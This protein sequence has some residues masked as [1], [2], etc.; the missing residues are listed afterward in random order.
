MIVRRFLLWARTASASD[1]AAGVRALA[2]AF[3]HAPMLEEDRREA[4]V[5]MLAMLDDPS[6]LV[7]RAMAEVLAGEKAPRAI[8]LGLARDQAD[9]A[10]FVLAAS[11]VLTQADL[12][13]AVA[14]GDDLTQCAVAQRSDV[15][16]ALAAAIVEVGSDNA[17]V[18]L[19]ENDHAEMA[20]STLQRA[21]DRAAHAP[22]LR[23]ALLKQPH[24]PIGIRHQLALNVAD[25][26]S[27][28]AGASGLM[29]RERA[30][31]VSRDASEK[32]AL[33]LAA[34]V[35]DHEE[36]L[37]VL[38]KQLRNSKRL[39]PGLILRSLLSGDTVLAEAALADLAG[40]PM[41]R[42]SSILRDRRGTGVAALCRKA[43]IP[44]MLVPAFV[45]AVEAV[46]VVGATAKDTQRVSMSRRIIE[47]VLIA[48]DGADDGTNAPLM[49]ML[50][51]FEA[52]AARAEA[53][54]MADTLA[55]EA[56]LAELLKIDPELT[57]LVDL[58]VAQLQ[59][60]N[61]TGLRAVA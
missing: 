33:E 48:C 56:A 16:I 29:T 15:S 12:I 40:M 17:I 57:L 55:D 49:A 50:R 3:L 54:M 45:A 11:P 43:D 22:T 61:E 35:D 10:A 58:E 23:E 20:A 51:R 19:I 26:L 9:V 60:A 2:E 36:E 47:R 25:C 53:Q 34:S 30:D 31:R 4:E 21:A 8:I 13:D 6:V 24:L 27:A 32:V 38:I 46:R 1:R 18:T 37:M 7:R 44:A 39:T 5:A 59:V 52:D 28:W 14:L 42:A 41:A